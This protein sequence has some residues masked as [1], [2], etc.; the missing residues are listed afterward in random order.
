MCLCSLGRHQCHPS[1]PSSVQKCP[2]ILRQKAQTKGL[3]L[4]HPPTNKRVCH[5]STLTGPPSPG[6]REAPHLSE[7]LHFYSSLGAS[8][9]SS[10]PSPSPTC[11]LAGSPTPLHDPAGP[12]ELSSSQNFISVPPGLPH[13]VTLFIASGI[14]KLRQSPSFSFHLHPSFPSRAASLLLHHRNCSAPTLG[15][16]IQFF[17]ISEAEFGVELPKSEETPP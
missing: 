10:H 11:A 5:C 9:P 16:C 13:L 3:S 7:E 1:C 2:F 6:A 8:L 14:D 4:I 17:C 12:A 15:L